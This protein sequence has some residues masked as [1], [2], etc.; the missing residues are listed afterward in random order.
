MTQ[1]VFS[2]EQ[3]KP[4]LPREILQGIVRDIQSTSTLAKLSGKEPMKFGKADIAVLNGHPKLE[5]VGEG[6]EKSSTSF[7][8]DS[9]S[10]VPHK[11]QVTL[12]YTNEVLW[13]DKDYQLGVISEVAKEAQVAASRG[14]DLGLYHAINPLTGQ[15][16]TF[17]NYLAKTTNVVTRDS[18]DAD[19]DFRTAVGLVMNGEKSYPVNGAAF[20]PAFAWE[21]SNL[22]VKDGSGLTSQ[23]RYPQLG[24]GQ[25]TQNF[26][27][28]PVAIGDTVSGRNDTTDA[29]TNKIRAI[30]GDFKNGI[31]W[32]IQREL[33]LQVILYGDPDGQGDLQRRNQIALRLEVVY[34]WYVFAERFALIKA[35]S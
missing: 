20:D 7:G 31:R 9:V 24:F 29:E 26:M 32:G 14:L 13:A 15:K 23:L 6:E 11:A 16:T 17:E 1:S 34:A 28:V 19:A 22:M 2:T 8:Y 27:G 30:V 4:L 3:L 35:N 18:A 33:P 10:V 25:D 12:R 5:F 21:L